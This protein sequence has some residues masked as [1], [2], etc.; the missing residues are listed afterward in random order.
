MD[1]LK[2]CQCTGLPLSELPEKY[3]ICLAAPLPAH[4]RGVCGFP[5]CVYAEGCS[6]GL[7]DA[8]GPTSECVCLC[9]C[10]WL[11]ERALVH[12]EEYRDV[13]TWEKK[14]MKGGRE[15]S[16]EQE[17]MI[18]EGEVWSRVGSKIVQETPKK[19]NERSMMRKEASD[20]VK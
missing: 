12:A 1:Q 15:R 16:S 4:R 13:G 17:M 3:R 18:A 10:L 7:N 2:R 19:S 6:E 5:I 8:G 20:Q 9:A 11:C 14:Q